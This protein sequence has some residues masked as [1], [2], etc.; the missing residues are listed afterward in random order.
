MSISD[1]LIHVNESLTDQ[2]QATLE[3]SMREIDGV[4]APRFTPGRQHLML[5][6]FDPEATSTAELLSRVR[7]FGYNAQLVGA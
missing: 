5:V 2:Q 4:V 6:A 7:S 1:I 3:A